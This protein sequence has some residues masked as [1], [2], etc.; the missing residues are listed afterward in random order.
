MQLSDGSSLL[1]RWLPAE[2]CESERRSPGAHLPKRTLIGRVTAGKVS[3][4]SA[5]FLIFVIDRSR[6]RHTSTSEK[7]SP[8]SNRKRSH[9][10]NVW[11]GDAD[12]PVLGGDFPSNFSARMRR[13]SMKRIFGLALA[14]SALCCGTASAQVS[15]GVVKLGVLNDMSSFYADIGG[16]VR[17]SPP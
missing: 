1:F 12:F 10:D 3:G 4:P 7:S 6:S 5:A 14:A 16:K 9:S 17:C 13:E 15:E 2:F 11:R 8:F